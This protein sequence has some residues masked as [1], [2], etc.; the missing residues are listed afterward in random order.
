MAHSQSGEGRHCA[1]SMWR[2]STPQTCRPSWILKVR[3]IAW[4]RHWDMAFLQ[5][6]VGSYLDSFELYL[7]K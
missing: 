2:A 5:E 7:G 6:F 1:L 4:P 3:G